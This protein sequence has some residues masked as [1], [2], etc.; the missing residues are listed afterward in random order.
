[1]CLRADSCKQGEQSG[2]IC[3]DRNYKSEKKIVKNLILKVR[4]CWNTI[5]VLSLELKKNEI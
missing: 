5:R 3:K 4:L 2:W 1:M